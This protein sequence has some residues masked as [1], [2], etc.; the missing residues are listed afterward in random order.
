MFFKKYKPL[1]YWTK[2]GKNYKDNFVHDEFF[3]TQEKTLMNYLKTLQFES[4]LEF[5]CGFGRITKLLVENFEIK[6]YKAFDLS[7]DQIKNAKNLCKDFE[8]DFEVSTVQDYEDS[9]KYNLVIG[10]EILMHIPPYEIESVLMKLSKF[11]NNHLINVDFY[12]EPLVTK[13]AKHNFCHDYNSLY[14]K[15]QN[16]KNINQIKINEKQSIFHAQF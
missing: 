3:K 5:G 12:E 6:I 10:S 15:L 14:K 4:V 13:L 2:R 7:P 8:I 9:Q 16:I 11:T 1:D